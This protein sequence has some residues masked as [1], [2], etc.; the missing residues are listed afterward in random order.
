[1]G[2]ERERERERGVKGRRIWGSCKKK[3]KEEE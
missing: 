2:E 3:K 1:M